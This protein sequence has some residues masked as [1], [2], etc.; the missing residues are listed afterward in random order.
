MFEESEQKAVESFTE[1]EARMK[2]RGFEYVGMESLTRNR[3]DAGAKFVVV[4]FQTKEDLLRKYVAG[5]KFDVEL[6]DDPCVK[7]GQKAVWVFL[8]EK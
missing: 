2:A 4:P 8:R 1:V 7:Q 6:I 5:G 3:F